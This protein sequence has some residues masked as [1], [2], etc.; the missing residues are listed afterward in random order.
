MFK[1]L[2]YKGCPFHTCD[3]PIGNIQGARV[4]YHEV[5]TF[6]CLQMFWVLLYFIN[7]NNMCINHCILLHTLILPPYLL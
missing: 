4:I 7:I 2:A 1:N 6:T 5:D 3:F